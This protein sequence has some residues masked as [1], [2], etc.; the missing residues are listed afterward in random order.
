M[1]TYNINPALIEKAITKKTKAIVPVHL[2]GQCA[3]MK[4][5]NDIAVGTKHRLS[6]LEDAAQSIFAKFD[7]KTCMAIGNRRCDELLSD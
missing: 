4:V 2:F 6:V 3:D 5:I 1:E 7:G